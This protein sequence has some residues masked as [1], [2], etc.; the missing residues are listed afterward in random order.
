MSSLKHN[1]SF[2]DGSFNVSVDG[3]LKFKMVIVRSDKKEWNKL[4]P[5]VIQLVDCNGDVVFSCKQSCCVQ[6]CDGVVPDPHSK[7]I[8]GFFCNKCWQDEDKRKIL[9]ENE[10]VKFCSLDG[11][12]CD[13]CKHRE[14]NVTRRVHTGPV[15]GPPSAAPTPID[16]D[17]IPIA[18]KYGLKAQQSSRVRGIEKTKR[19]QKVFANLNKRRLKLIC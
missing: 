3:L 18:K 12:Q 7:T 14:D 16:D 17:D 9:I 8:D 4:R 6:G 5:N 2:F 1:A 13:Q 15:F 10:R 19:L 11:R